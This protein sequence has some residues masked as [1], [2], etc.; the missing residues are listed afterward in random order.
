VRPNYA[1]L[2]A[3]DLRDLPA[4]VIGLIHRDTAVLERKR[5]RLGGFDAVAFPLDILRYVEEI[6]GTGD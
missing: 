4:H 5:A 3:T 1:E 6:A 2:A